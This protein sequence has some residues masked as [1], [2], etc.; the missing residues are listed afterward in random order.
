M[1]PAI[2]VKPAAFVTPLPTLVLRGMIFLSELSRVRRKSANLAGTLKGRGG[3]FVHIAVRLTHEH[4]EPHAHMHLLM[5]QWN[6]ARV[7]FDMAKWLPRGWT[8]SSHTSLPYCHGTLS[9]AIWLNSTGHNFSFSLLQT[10][11]NYLS[12]L[13]KNSALYCLISNPASNQMG[14]CTPIE[15]KKDMRSRSKSTSGISCQLFLRDYVHWQQ[16]GNQISIT[17]DGRMPGS[18]TT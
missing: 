10:K 17:K 12:N 5:H 9:S 8:K 4:G 14:M 6:K 3:K 15:G 16:N 2:I 11:C 18:P 7:H 13:G 1:S